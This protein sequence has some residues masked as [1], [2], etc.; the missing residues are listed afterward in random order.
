MASAAE[1][2][3][4]PLESN[5]GSMNAVSPFSKACLFNRSL[6]PTPQWAHSLG[7]DTSQYSF[8]DV[9]ALDDELLSWVQQPCKAVLMLFP[10]T[11]AFERERRA[12]DER[13]LEHGMPG[14]AG[15]IF[16][17][18]RIRNACGTFALLHALAN[19]QGLPIRTYVGLTRAST[20]SSR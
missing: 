12:T 18:Q 9:F 3:W 6:Q 1:Q 13:T 10:I 15:R 7:L 5:P 16:F 11:D 19:A 20:P 14:V 17:R 4:L 8:Q 2:R